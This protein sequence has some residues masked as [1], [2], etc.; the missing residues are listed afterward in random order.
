MHG[1]RAKINSSPK[2]STEK[3]TAKIVLVCRLLIKLVNETS[4]DRVVIEG[5]GVRAE[6]IDNSIDYLQLLYINRIV[7][8]LRGEKGN[9]PSVFL[10]RQLTS[11]LLSH[12]G[13]GR[14]VARR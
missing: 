6:I 4:L 13:R 8:C 10:G 11:R 2:N 9:S 5:M 1:L 12:L 3:V 7:R 14:A